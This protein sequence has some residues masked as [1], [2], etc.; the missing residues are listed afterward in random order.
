M[1][2][3]NIYLVQVRGKILLSIIHILFLKITKFLGL[4]LI[5][6]PGHTSLFLETVK[7]TFMGPRGRGPRAEKNKYPLNMFFSFFQS[8]DR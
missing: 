7:I 3:W 5:P 2:S 6:H 4:T 1:A 8:I